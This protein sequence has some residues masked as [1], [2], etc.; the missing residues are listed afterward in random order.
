M[1]RRKIPKHARKFYHRG[2]K[3]GWYAGQRSEVRPAKS[4]KDKIAAKVYERGFSNQVA[5]PITDERAIKWQGFT[6]AMNLIIASK[7]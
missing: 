1:K 3:A 6:E 7:R 5:A 2:Y 4:D